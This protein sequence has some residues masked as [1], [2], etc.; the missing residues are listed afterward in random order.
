M[1][2]EWLQMESGIGAGGFVRTALNSRERRVSDRRILKVLRQW[3]K[4]GVVDDGAWRATE[5][6]SPQG[7]VI[8]PLLANI[9]LDYLDRAWTR[10]CAHLGRLVRY[11]DDFVVLCKTE[12]AANEAMRRLGIILEHLRLTMHHDKTRIVKLGPGKDGFVFL[13]CTLRIVRSHFRKK[14]YLFRWPSPRSMNKIRD[15]VR[16]LTNRPR[17][18]GIRDLGVVIRDLNPILRGWGNYFRTG[19]ASDKFQQVDRFVRRRLIRL[20]S[21]RGGD[22][23]KPVNFEEWTWARLQ[24]L[25]LHRLIGTIRYPGK[26]HAA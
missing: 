23:A 12:E 7:G 18:A 11:A 16:E 3:L 15:R 6:G 22:R 1:S 8:S 13:G 20:L 14:D 24:K 4:A 25:G 26:A 17:R 9:F 21:R 10:Q 2:Y 5:V 19:N